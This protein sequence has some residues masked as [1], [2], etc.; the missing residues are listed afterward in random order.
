MADPQIFLDSCNGKVLLHPGAGLTLQKT[1]MVTSKIKQII[2]KQFLGGFTNIF[3]ISI[4]TK[5]FWIVLPVQNAESN[6]KQMYDTKMPSNQQGR[7]TDVVK[8]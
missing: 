7:H 1:A 2:A 5:T 8:T 4:I 6:G 3:A